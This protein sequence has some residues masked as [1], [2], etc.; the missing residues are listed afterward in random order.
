MALLKSLLLAYVA[1]ALQATLIPHLAIAGI[2]PDL[3]LV[4]VV[5]L[6]YA[7]GSIAGTLAGFFIGLAQDLTNPGFLGLN[8]LC[9]AVLGYAVGSLRLQLDTGILPMR[10]AVLFGSVLAHDLLYLTILTRLELSELLLGLVARS[11][12]TALYTALVGMWAVGAAGSLARRGVH[13][14]GRPAFTRR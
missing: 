7:R 12:P 13:T 1:L 8:A 5:L 11:L 6:A 10:A 2:R 9:K 14:H 4:A 3:P